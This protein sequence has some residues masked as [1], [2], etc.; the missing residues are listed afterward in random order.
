MNKTELANIY[1]SALEVIAGND[2]SWAGEEARIVLANPEAWRNEHM[3][4]LVRVL[5]D[6]R[7]NIADKRVQEEL[8]ALGWTGCEHFDCGCSL[9][10]ERIQEKVYNLYRRNWLREEKRKRKNQASVGDS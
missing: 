1:R 9:E 3:P 7:V 4:P 6:G 8:Q 10:S 5:P 2:A